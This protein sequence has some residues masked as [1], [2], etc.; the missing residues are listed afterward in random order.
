MDLAYQLF[1]IETRGLMAEAVR[2]I[3]RGGGPWERGELRGLETVEG[4]ER[5]LGWLQAEGLLR[6]HTIAWP[7]LPAMRRVAKLLERAGARLAWRDG[8]DYPKKLTL[9]LGEK[10]PA[11]VW[12]AGP[13]ERLAGATCAMIGSRQTPP[14]LLAA[15]R[16][17]GRALAE[18]GM[19]VV[20]GMAEGADTASHEGARAGAAGTVIVPARG[21]LT[22]GLPINLQEN[23]GTEAGKA[24]WVGLDRPDDGFSAG[25]AIRRNDVIAALGDAM[26]LVASGLKGGS[27]YGVRWALGH[28]VPLYCFEC[29]AATPPANR[30]LIHA[31]QAVA[32]GL[33]ESE[34]AWVEKVRAGVEA[35]R[36]AAPVEAEA[37]AGRQ[38]AGSSAEQL[39]FF[40]A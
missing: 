38:K 35:R 7:P 39:D 40:G 1:L 2:A 4:R 5:L 28:G 31:G 36:A 13:E 25:L 15:A 24:T 32:L 18:A 11:W 8:E 22:A 34:A 14:R 12:L 37:K 26:V 33:G 19:A 29:A 30:A 6:G 21:L 9:G 16:R 27:S 10:A 17:L 20:S 3:V 23:A